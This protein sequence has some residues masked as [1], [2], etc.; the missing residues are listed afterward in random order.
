M[1]KLDW[2]DTFVYWCYT[3]Y[4]FFFICW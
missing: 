1:A 2:G 4:I 3:M